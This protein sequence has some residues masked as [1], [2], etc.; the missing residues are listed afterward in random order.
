MKNKQQS[1]N[2]IIEVDKKHAIPFSEWLY[3]NN[4]QVVDVKIKLQNK[5]QVIIKRNNNEL[6]NLLYNLYLKKYNLSA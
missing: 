6:T 5:S 3:L 1:D 4:I 2:I